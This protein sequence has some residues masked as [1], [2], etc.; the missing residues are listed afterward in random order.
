M[1]FRND[2]Y[3]VEMNRRRKAVGSLLLCAGAV[4]M[5]K[6]RMQQRQTPTIRDEFLPKPNV[7][8]WRLVW[9][10]GDDDAFMACTSLTRLA[11]NKLLGEFSK[12]Y[13][14]NF[15]KGKGGRPP[16]LVRK[17]DVL[18]F[19][20][21]YLVEPMTWK[22]MCQIYG[23]PRST[24]NRTQV[25][26]EEALRKALQHLQD[27]AIRWPTLLEQKLWAR[28]VQKK[29]PLVQGRWGFADGKNYN[30]ME[31]SCNADLQNAMYNGWLHCVFITGVLLYG[32]DGTIC[33][34][35]HNFVG[36]WNDGETS[37][38]LQEKL[39]REDINAPGH[40]ILTDTAFPCVNR[41]LGRI[42][43]PAKEGEIEKAPRRLRGIMARLSAAITSVRQAAEWGMGA[44]EKVYQRLAKPLTFDPTVRARRLDIMFRLYNFRVRTTG[45]SQIRSVF[46]PNGYP[47]V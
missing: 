35:R 40:G 12:H 46:F 36:S 5:M 41:L 24:A 45:V 17:E 30:V 25:K 4:L 15:N 22:G 13:Q 11:F 43:T 23:I 2:Q 10:H 27:A 34:V 6:L 39:M 9:D 8:A 29:E 20:L 7:S 19:V 31:P 21:R 18:A 47:H 37:R 33:W 14:F 32:A 26:A 38:K 16:R 42:M 1:I 3:R 28:A 44:V